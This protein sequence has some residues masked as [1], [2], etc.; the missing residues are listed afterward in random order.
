MDDRQLV[1]RISGEVDLSLQPE[2]RTITRH[3]A[4]HLAHDNGRAVIDLTH[5]TFSDAT[6]ARFLAGAA[7]HGAVTVQAPN[8]VAREFLMLYGISGV[9]RGV[10]VVR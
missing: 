6:L 3:L 1:I 8:R 5:M 4:G 9:D 2:L 7:E 10:R